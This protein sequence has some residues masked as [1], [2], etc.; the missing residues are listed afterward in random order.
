MNILHLDTATAVFSIAL[1]ADEQ[2]IG[3]FCGDA[4]PATS[5][6]IPGHIQALLQ[7]A[8]LEMNDLHAFAVTVGP[9]AFTGVRVGIALTKGM[10]YATGKPVIP[11]SSLELLALNAKNSAIPVCALFDARRS[12]V[13][14]A[15]Y[16]FENGM[17][18]IRPEM[19]IT[20]GR[21]LDELS[22]P[23]LFIGDGALR[24]RDLIVERFGSNAHFAEQHLHQPKASAG[25]ALALG[26][27]QS[28]AAVS[29]EELMPCYLRLAEAEI[30]RRRLSE[31]LA[32]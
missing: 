25:A 26:F 17:Q 1:S 3:E 5:A 28:G 8:S 24:Y 16:L 32:I 7:Q 10:A 27:L 15:L 13:Y 12:E 18:R 9:G 6:K 11:L 14:S 29:P 30:N 23:T 20:P 4:G 19:A 22:G 2:V 31:E 21:L